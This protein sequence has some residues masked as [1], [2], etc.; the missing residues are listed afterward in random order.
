MISIRARVFKSRQLP[1]S[2]RSILSPRLFLSLSFLPKNLS[3]WRHVHRLSEHAIGDLGE[4]RT[5]NGIPRGINDCEAASLAKFK[6]EDRMADKIYR[7]I[8]TRVFPRET[9]SDKCRLTSIISYINTDINTS[10]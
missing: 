7:V 2:G 1:V 5:I 9:F 4:N 10:S 3:G 6:I 8:A